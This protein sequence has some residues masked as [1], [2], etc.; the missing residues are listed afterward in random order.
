M[1]DV[2][3]IQKRGDTYEHSVALRYK[4]IVIYVAWEEP[5]KFHPFVPPV[6][7]VFDG[8]RMLVV[9]GNWLAHIDTEPEYIIRD[10][11]PDRLH[12]L[13]RRYN[14]ERSAFK[15]EFALCLVPRL[16]RDVVSYIFRFC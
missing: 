14:R 15:H 5:N 2:H 4:S 13:A 6:H 16:G 12:Q 10:P 8:H 1:Q 11:M 7:L 9:P 3:L